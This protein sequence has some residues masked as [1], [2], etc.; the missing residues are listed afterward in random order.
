MFIRIWVDVHHALTSHYL[1]HINSQLLFRIYIVPPLICIY[2]ELYSFHFFFLPLQHFH[3]G[4]NSCHHFRKNTVRFS[5]Q[6]WSIWVIMPRVWGYLS[7]R[8]FYYNNIKSRHRKYRRIGWL[9]LKGKFNWDKNQY[10]SNG[11]LHF[12]INKS[13]LITLIIPFSSHIWLID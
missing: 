3:L 6:K 4:W 9:M 10:D 1:S 2:I 8:K 5:T 13:P 12:T 11:K 7:G